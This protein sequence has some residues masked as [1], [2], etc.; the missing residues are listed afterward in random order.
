MVLAAESKRLITA[1]Q[2]C[3]WPGGPAHSFT[4][5]PGLNW[6]CGGE[7]RGKSSLLQV[8]AGQRTPLSGRLNK[9]PMSCWAEHTVDPSLDH[10]TGQAWLAA[11]QARYPSW[12]RPL[13]A[14]LSEAL[15]LEEHLPKPFYMLSA[16]SRRKV[17]LLAAAASGADLVL[18]DTP[19]AALD[20]RSCRLLDELLSDA[21][22]S[23]TQIWVIADYALPAGLA[24]V[25]LAG[26]VDLG[27]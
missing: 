20:L 7:Q 23:R 1:E 15:H 27:E 14:A 4:L 5:G 10:T 26:V 17:G 24:G 13:A 22:D 3:W 8:L 12:Q 2:L 21:A 16:G 25:T 11:Q 6:V 19:Y 9:P 18:L